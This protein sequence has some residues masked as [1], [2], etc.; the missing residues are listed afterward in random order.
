MLSPENEPTMSSET[1]SI[2]GKIKSI[3]GTQVV[4]EVPLPSRTTESPVSN[5]SVRRVSVDGYTQVTTE[6][7]KNVEGRDLMEVGTWVIAILGSDSITRFIS[8]QPQ[9]K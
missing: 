4:I 2:Q 3:N 9:E 6:V 7:S 5:Y 1:R 8:V